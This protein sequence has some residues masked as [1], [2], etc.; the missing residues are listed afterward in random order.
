MRGH[1]T[2]RVFI[3]IVVFVGLLAAVETLAAGYSRSGGGGDYGYGME[4][5]ELAM[6]GGISS[7]SRSN[8]LQDNPA[9]LIYNRGADLN[10]QGVTNNDQFNPVNEE[11]RL[12]YGYHEDFAFGGGAHTYKDGSTTK[13]AADYGGAFYLREIYT[14]I[15][16]SATTERPAT[17]T[18]GAKNSSDYNITALFNPNGQTRIGVGFMNLV[19]GVHNVVAGVSSDVVRHFSLG[20]DGSSD[21]DLHGVTLIPSA[22]LHLGMLELSGG[23]GARVDKR[24]T[25]Y[26]ADKW[27]AGAGLKL[28]RELEIEYRYRHMEQHAVALTARF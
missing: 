13:Y 5:G 18:Q 16:A 14:A 11:A 25:S 2:S 7:P 4:R 21:Q 20:V 9:A 28:G 24:T 8:A 22:A 3:C 10:V 15:G 26:Y 23:Y 6:G 19:G 1:L 12:L 17:L 27:T